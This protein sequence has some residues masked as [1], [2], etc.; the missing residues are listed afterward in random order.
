[1]GP[2]VFDLEKLFQDPP[3]SGNA[4]DLSG[5]FERV[6]NDTR[7]GLDLSDDPGLDR[8]DDEASGSR[9]DLWL[10]PDPEEGSRGRSELLSLDEGRADDEWPA[11][12]T[13]GSSHNETSAERAHRDDKADDGMR[14]AANGPAAQN[15]TAERPET[16]SSDG[17]A[18]PIESD[19]PQSQ[20]HPG[21]ERVSVPASQGLTDASAVASGLAAP[22]FSG[23]TPAGPLASPGSTSNL[24]PRT[25]AVASPSIAP[26]GSGANIPAPAQSKAGE[27]STP[28]GPGVR[29]VA[30]N[31]ALSVAASSLSAV[32][33]AAAAEP[34]AP[35]DPTARLGISPAVTVTAGQNAV[36]SRPDGTLT[37]A[38][39]LAAQQAAISSATPAP[40]VSVATSGAI[41]TTSGGTA[42]ASTTHAQ[43]ASGTQGQ[44]DIKAAVQGQNSGNDASQTN[45][46]AANQSGALL[47]QAKS[48]ASP[49]GEGRT[50]TG[51]VPM[52]PVTSNQLET[53]MG[54]GASSL[55]P[56]A[57]AAAG[58]AS[59]IQSVAP[60]T[61]T[62]QAVEFARSPAGVGSAAEQVALQIHKASDGGQSRLNLPLHPAELGRVQVMMETVDNG[63]LR[64]V[65]LAE[66]PEAL[67]LLQRDARGLERALQ[68]AGL[69]TDSQSLAFERH[70]AGGD[71]RPGQNDDR[72]VNAE[73]AQADEPDGHGEPPA[74]DA[75]HN[76]PDAD[77][78]LDISV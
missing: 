76:G 28:N 52:R 39:G 2:I 77:G 24:S 15:Q 67:E 38:T 41:L 51:L 65:I 43:A 35:S 5:L 68:D 63:V 56:P 26:I 21:D 22:G 72:S 78:H 10:R 4:G 32:S 3:G 45:S 49:T 13:A 20:G 40:S 64:A 27:T 71:G 69:K 17:A 25:A 57:I 60:V 9:T 47:A 66:R 14:Q 48:Q 70:G 12:R 7:R 75:G 61:M 30:T 34:P 54:R 59:P 53:S 23:N 16:F 8:A 29:P 55:T 37:A 33:G 58:G 18:S 11:D 62:H 42:Q 44:G 36:T 1:M 74:D 73:E 50:F 46:Q 19:A 31:G 6:L